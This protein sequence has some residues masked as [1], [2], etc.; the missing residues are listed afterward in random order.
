MK[1]FNRQTEEE[2]KLTKDPEMSTEE[3]NLFRTTFEAA[4][5]L[6]QQNSPDVYNFVYGINRG[7]FPIE[8]IAKPVETVKPKPMY[9]EPLS[10][11]LMTQNQI[12][13]LNSLPPL[14]FFEANQVVPMTRPSKQRG[15][16][17]EAISGD[18]NSLQFRSDVIQ[19]G[20][21]RNA[22]SGIIIPHTRSECKGAK[23]AD[24]FYLKLL[25]MLK[26]DVDRFL[27]RTDEFQSKLIG[28]LAKDILRKNFKSSTEECTLF[29]S[30][31]KKLIIE[32]G[33]SFKE[34]MKNF[35]FV[36][37]RERA[38]KHP[39]FSLAKRLMDNNEI[40]FKK[41]WER[42]QNKRGKES[43]L[44]EFKRRVDFE[45][46]DILSLDDISTFGR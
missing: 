38:F 23:Q 7:L 44:E 31:M 29:S 18:S 30:D 9:K 22:F 15:I 1:P 43:S 19:K 41:F 37:Q 34:D 21:F 46:N 13:F 10:P 14:G 17:E 4:S 36:P 12:L 28:P 6:N 35:S 16:N 20:W 2:Q 45:M 42:F 26:N 5:I 11:N 32:E 27:Q 3:Q 40:Y 39:I 33:D 24:K 8:S 25:N